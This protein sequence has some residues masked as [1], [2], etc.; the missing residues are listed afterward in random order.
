MEQASGEKNKGY[1]T[2]ITSNGTTYDSSNTEEKTGNDLFK[3][4]GIDATVR[5]LIEIIYIYNIVHARAY[6]V[7]LVVGGTE[8]YR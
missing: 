4:E 2:S 8:K 3:V 5:L 7:K 1:F 6:N